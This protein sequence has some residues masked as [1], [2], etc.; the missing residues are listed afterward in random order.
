MG[1][2]FPREQCQ[3][4]LRAAFYNNERAVEYLCNGIPQGVENQPNPQSNP[5]PISGQGL[6]QAAQGQG[7]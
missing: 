4:A 2:G 7:G 1:M 6:G 3:A 5:P